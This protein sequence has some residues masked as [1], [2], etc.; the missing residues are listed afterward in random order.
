MAL[1]VC[2]TASSAFHAIYDLPCMI[3]YDGQIPITT[4]CLV[5]VE[6]SNDV[7]YETIRTRNGKSFVIQKTDLAKW[8]LDHEQ[9]IKVSDEP[10]TCYQ[11]R[12]VKI[13][14]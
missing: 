4:T 8:Y 5:N 7:Y 2:A 14:L 9:A 3:S 10:N 6:A 13:C 1:T 12:Q 11:N